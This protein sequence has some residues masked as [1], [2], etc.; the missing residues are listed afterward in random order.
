MLLSDLRDL[1]AS[2]SI[3]K[4]PS[5]AIRDALAEMETRPWPEWNRGQ[6]LALL[7]HTATFA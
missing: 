2:R 7:D 1:F 4:L 5:V 3:D 6:P